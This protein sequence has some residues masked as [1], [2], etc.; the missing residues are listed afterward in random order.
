MVPAHPGCISEGHTLEDALKNIR[1]AIENVYSYKRLHS[2]LNC[3]SPV[4]FEV[5]VALNTIA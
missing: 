3:R 2:A 5:E 4:Q 1:E